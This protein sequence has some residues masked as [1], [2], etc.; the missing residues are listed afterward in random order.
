MK[1]IIL[2]FAALGMLFAVSAYGDILKGCTCT[3]GSPLGS[4]TCKSIVL[5][6]CLVDKMSKG[7]RCDT[8]ANT[9]TCK[10]TSISCGAI[11]GT[12]NTDQECAYMSCQPDYHPYCCQDFVGGPGR[13][14]CVPPSG[15]C[16]P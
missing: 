15:G 4:C 11:P 8:T 5:T 10:K 1:K 13:C 12:C 2:A 14:L 6:G 16:M 9:C 7:C 3:P